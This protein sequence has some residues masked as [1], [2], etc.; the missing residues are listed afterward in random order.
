MTSKFGGIAVEETQ[1]PTESKFGGVAVDEA[2]EEDKNLGAAPFINRAIASSA[3][4]PVDIVTN[5]LNVIPGVNIQEPI[6]GSKSIERA[7]KFWLGVNVPD[8]GPEEISEYIGTGIGEV[9]SFLVPVGTGFKIASKGPRL[10]HKIASNIW[11]TM[12]KHPYLT[13]VSELTGGA[14]AGAGRYVGEKKFPESPALR[15]TMEIAGGMV[16]GMAPTITQYAPSAIAFKQGKRLVQKVSLPFTEKGAKYRAGEY[17]K[18]RVAEPHEAAIKTG[19]ETISDLP[20]VI[21]TGEKRLTELYKS[22]ISQDPVAD[23]DTIEKLTRSM[24]KL[25]SEMRKFG[26]GSPDLLVEITQKRIAALE[27][28]MDKRVVTATAKAQQKLAALPVAQRKGS[29]SR[30]V[31]NEL[32][33]VMREEKS[34]V[35]NLWNDVPK[36]TPVS[37]E[38]TRRAHKNI[39]DSLAN[40]QKTDIP[41]VLKKEPIIKNQ[42]LTQTTLREMQGLR[43]KLLETARIARKD[44][45]WNRARIANEVADAILDDIGIVADSTVT[46][47]AK[48]LQVALA[49]TRKFKERFETGIVGKIFG[50]DRSGAPTISPELTLDISIGR[51]GQ[52]GS[53]DINKIAITPEAR[54][55]TERYLTRSYADYALDTVSGTINPIKSEKWIRNNE[56]ILD[57]FSNLRNR[58][59][60]AAKSQKVATNLHLAMEARKKALRDPKISTAARFLNAADM[61][62]EV[63]SIFN[64]KRPAYIARELARQTRKDSTGDALGGLRG[65]MIDYILEKSSIGAFNEAGEQTLSGYT[66]L[67]FINKNNA[68]LREVFTPDQIMRMKKIG[69]E[70][71]KIETFEKISAGKAEV[72]MQDLASGA[73][74]MFSRVSGAQAGRWVAKVTGGGTVQTPGIFSEKFKSFANFLVK[75]RAFQLIH[76]A[77][78][79]DNPKLLQALLLPIDKP[80]TRATEINLRILNERMNLWLAG[81]GKRVLDDIMEEMRETNNAR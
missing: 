55:A 15:T 75:D 81:T 71:A 51:M 59:M 46:A 72:E 5:A 66:L 20:P 22:L 61:D 62:M 16:G 50:Y 37:F 18:G 39:T 8:R 54:A 36:D 42:K 31:R 77:V 49:A 74:K 35:D 4:A 2:Q 23:A 7:M 45:Q 3:G 28:N 78:L 53:I 57:Q 67:S 11:S 41:G 64:A 44:G 70:L 25:E 34:K 47:E 68:T 40:A 60:E 38:K 24:V 43:S 27:L 26:Y 21:A 12:V 29:E 19:E 9:A 52:R 13:M 69:K 48:K 32:V 76:D 1:E 73:L 63:E 58:F 65:G 56:A 14:G 10:A 6:G 17:I 30:I 80:G 79:A 33:K